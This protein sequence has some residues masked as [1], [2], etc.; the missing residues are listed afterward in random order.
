MNVTTLN[1]LFTLFQKAAVQADWKSALEMLATEL[2]PFIVF[3]NIAI[4]LIDPQIKVLDVAYARA[5]GRGKSAEADA[6]WGDRIAAKVVAHGQVVIQTPTHKFKTHTDRLELSHLL[7]LPLRAEAQLSGAVVFVRFGGP[8]FSDEHLQVAALSAMWMSC[9]FERRAW[10]DT[11][12]QLDEVQRRIRLQDDFLAT[13]SH[14]L[15]TPLGFIKGYST[16]LLRQDTSWDTNTQREFLTI[17]DEEADRLTQLIEDLLESARLQSNTLQFKFQPLRLDALVRD[18]VL[19]LMQR[20]PGLS[21]NLDFGVVPPIPGDNVHLTRVFEN[22]FSNAIKYAPGSALDVS[23]AQQQETIHIQFTDH[24]PGV[25]P[26]HQAMI[27][28]RFYRVPNENTANTGTGLGLYICEQIIMAHHGK[29]WVE[30][31]PGRGTTFHI[32]LPLD[33]SARSLK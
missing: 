27:F 22:L 28:E 23:F 2:R 5:L 14:E 33:T 11:Y 10:Q 19:R 25:P 16:T 17:I 12:Q 1:S 8:E 9:L 26:E 21:V 13:I 3:D 15:R 31:A 30:S 29:I 18:V 4:Y 20:H 7:G 6:A 32:E 24:G